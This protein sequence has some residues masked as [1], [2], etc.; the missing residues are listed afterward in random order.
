MVDKS[1]DRKPGGAGIGLAICN[2]TAK[3]HGGYINV[4]SREGE[5]TAISMYM[6]LKVTD[7]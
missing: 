4:A 2:L 1:R 3:L 7:S 5:G 6:P